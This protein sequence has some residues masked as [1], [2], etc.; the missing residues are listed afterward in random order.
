VIW[1]IWKLD[2]EHLINYRRPS[3]VIILP[4]IARRR[5]TQ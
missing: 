1:R 2:R 5:S 4:Q 3:Q